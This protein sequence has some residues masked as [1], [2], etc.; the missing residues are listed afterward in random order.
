MIKLTENSAFIVKLQTRVKTSESH[1]SH[2]S[3]L[4]QLH[5]NEWKEDCFFRLKSFES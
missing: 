4:K 1:K 2:S 5:W 3:A